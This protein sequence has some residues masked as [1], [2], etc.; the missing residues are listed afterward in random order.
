VL[1]E[2]RVADGY[3]LAA[4][5]VI[6]FWA[7]QVLQETIQGIP[8]GFWSTGACRVD[9]VRVSPFVIHPSGEAGWVE[10]VPFHPAGPRVG[11]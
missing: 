1:G 5:Q 8:S 3:S 11:W 9:A 2:P 7:H 6:A 4:P 10:Y